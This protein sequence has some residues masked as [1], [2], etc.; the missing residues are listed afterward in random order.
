MAMKDLR[1]FIFFLLALAGSRLAQQWFLVCQAI[2]QSDG[3]GL[4]E[5]SF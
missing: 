1:R 2:P 3:L 5:S 4:I